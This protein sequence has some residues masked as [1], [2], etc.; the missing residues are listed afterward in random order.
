[1]PDADHPDL[2][3]LASRARSRLADAVATAFDP[4]VLVT[5]TLLVVAARAAENPLAGVAWALAAIAGCALIPEV[6]LRVLV[7]SGRVRDR[8]LVLREQRHVPMLIAAASVTLTL[9]AL[10]L[11][12]APR[13]LLALIVT[14]LVGL[15]AITLVTRFWKASIHAD[16]AA[17]CA[18]VAAID[19][20]AW[21]LC[22]TVP[23]VAAVAWARVRAGRHSLA[24]AAVGILLGTAITAAAF[25]R[26]L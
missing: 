24:Q 23:I 2:A 8:Q 9:V 14:I 21:T 6:V 1:M 17:T 19:V 15:A 13:P 5:L 22:L 10:A 11:L 18:T 7:R 12:G 20:G 3:R 4:L 26:L 16:V 25:P